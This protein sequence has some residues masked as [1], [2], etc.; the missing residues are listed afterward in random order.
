MTKGTKS[1]TAAFL[2]IR[3]DLPIDYL[4][5]AH[6]VADGI[7]YIHEEQDKSFYSLVED[8]KEAPRMFSNWYSDLKAKVVL[9]VQSEAVIDKVMEDLTRKNIDHTVIMDRRLLVSASH[10]TM[11]G[12]AIYPIKRHYL[13]KSVLDLELYR[14]NEKLLRENGNK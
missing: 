1:K 7:D 4:D 11:V 5:L 8:P 6:F 14:I 12:I 2:L 13:P 3:E 10:Q 9:G